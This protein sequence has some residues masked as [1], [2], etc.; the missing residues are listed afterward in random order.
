MLR[1]NSQKFQIKTDNQQDTL[2]LGNKIGKTLK[3]GEFFLLSSDLGGGKTTFTK[4]LLQGLDSSDDVTSPT[5]TVSNLY[6][7]R[8]N[9]EVHHF[10]FYRLSEGGMVAYE[11]AEIINDPNIIIVVEWGDVVS[12]E[13]PDS[14]IVIEINRTS[15][16]EDSRQFNIDI[17]EEYN[18]IGK[19]L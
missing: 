16:S 3:G 14:K 2:N 17:P 12:D 19:V 13:L 6:N 8:D 18:Y 11:L 10:D 15:E 4:G 9:L 7:G 1:M 5:F